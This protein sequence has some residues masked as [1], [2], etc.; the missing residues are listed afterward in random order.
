VYRSKRQLIDD[1]G[2]VV[3][4]FHDYWHRNQP[5]GIRAGVL[6][7]L[8]WQAY[9]DP[10]DPSVCTI[11]PRSLSTLAAELK[12]KLG[13]PVARATGDPDMICRRVTLSLGAGGGRWQISQIGRHDIDTIVCGEINEWETSEYVRDAVNAGLKKGLI[14]VGHVHSEEP[15]MKW[16]V[17]WLSARL[18]GVPIAHVPAG[19]PFRY[20]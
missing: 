10:V 15:G 2:I 9:A 16:L 5:D 4:R 19:D 20:F 1:H 17:A 7:Q 14:V 3:W 18:P 13:V 6:E 8:G 12:D 11:P